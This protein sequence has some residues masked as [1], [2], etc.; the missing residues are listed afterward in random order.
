VWRVESTSATPLTTDVLFPSW[1]AGARATLVAR[2]GAATPIGD[3][4]IPV[5]TAGSVRIRSA[6]TGYTVAI[7]DAP[8][9]TTARLLPNRPQPSAPHAG[10]TVAL[11]L[12]R[13]ERFQVTGLRI[14]ITTSRTGA[15]YR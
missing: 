14:Q 1:G 11:Q 9:G 2:D 6:G 13:S 5:A 3:A 7:R 10:P 15:G 12:T 4:P 8:P